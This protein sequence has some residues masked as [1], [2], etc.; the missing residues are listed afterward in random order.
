MYI[1]AVIAEKMAERAFNMA[2]TAN[3]GV[4]ALQKSLAVPRLMSKKQL[5]QNELAKDQVNGLFSNQ[6]DGSG[7]DWLRPILSD[8]ENDILDKVSEHNA[9]FNTNEKPLP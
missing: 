5:N 8:K 2:S 6:V 1:R 7:F 3:L 9:K 4:V